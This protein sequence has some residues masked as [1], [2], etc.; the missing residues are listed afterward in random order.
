M[1]ESSTCPGSQR[2]ASERAWDRILVP[3]D[4][5]RDASRYRDWRQRSVRHGVEMTGGFGLAGLAWIS[6]SNTFVNGIRHGVVTHPSPITWEFGVCVAGIALG[7]LFLLASAWEP[8]PWPGKKKAIRT[9]Q[10]ILEESISHAIL[11]SNIHIRPIGWQDKGYRS[12]EY[13]ISFENGRD[14]VIEFEILKWV[15]EFETYKQ[16][17]ED[18][19]GAWFGRILPG[20]QVLFC[21]PEIRT[22]LSVM[23]AQG[24][25]SGLLDY[26]A[27]YGSVQGGRKRILRQKLKLRLIIPDSKEWIV[28]WEPVIHDEGWEG[29]S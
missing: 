11:I 13:E 12:V 7:A 19:S 20:R 28:R 24:E 27:R 22:P 16:D 8:M 6:A 4:F 17:E 3:G 26:V 1:A 21:G 14:E 9:D 10:K 18:R 23:T 29:A 15:G 2:T 25:Y 5:D